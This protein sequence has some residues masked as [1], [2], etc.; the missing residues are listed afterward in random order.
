M[1]N[2]VLLRCAAMASREIGGPSAPEDILATVDNVAWNRAGRLY[3]W[4]NHVPFSL[5]EAWSGLSPDARLAVFAMACELA[6]SEEP[7]N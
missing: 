2:E 1:T 4:R 3:D 7:S 5:R 6:S